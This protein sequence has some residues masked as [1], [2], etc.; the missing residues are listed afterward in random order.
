ME[1]SIEEL[2]DIEVTS[3]SKKKQKLYDA[4]AAIFVITHDDIRRSGVTSIPD[5]L[6][7]APGLEVART[8]SARWAVTSRGFNDRFANKLLVLIDGRSIYT[9]LF[10]GV[11]W[12][13]K[14]LILDDI[15]RI[16]IIRGPGATLWG[17]NAVNGVINII[18]KETDETHGAL[19]IIGGGS[20][21]RGFG[22]VR[23]GGTINDNSSYRIFAK[24]FNRDSFA[25]AD[26]TDAADGWEN[27]T[28]GF[29]VDWNPS[30][31]DS[32]TFSGGVYNGNTGGN[33]G[34][35][36]L[37]PPFKI[38]IDTDLDQTGGHLLG[39][40]THIS[41]NDSETSLQMYY[42]RTDRDS[43]TFGEI[44][45]TFDVDIQR[46][47][48]LL[49]R[50]EIVF[51]GRYRYTVD[52]TDE[53][54]GDAFGTSFDPTGRGDHLFS[55]FVQDEITLIRDRLRLTLGSKFEHNDYTGF[56]YQPNIR[57]AW[58]PSENQTVWASVSRAVR[59]PARIEDDGRINSQALQNPFNPDG[60]PFLGALFGDHDAESEDL[61]AFEL[62]YRIQPT[63]R[64]SI[65][66]AGFF[67]RYDS[68]RTL[69]TG[70]L[71]FEATNP[72][73]AH[74]L[75]PITLN[76]GMDGETYGIEVS[77]DYRP[78]DWFRLTGYYTYLDMQ[79]H[80]DN[81]SNDTMLEAAEGQSP[82]NQFSLRA[83]VDL[84]WDME[85]DAWFRYV[86][87]LPALEIDSYVTLD[88]RVG[89]NPTANLELE[90]VGQNLLDTEHQEFSSIFFDSPSIEIERGIYGSV[91]LK[92]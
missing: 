6:R 88:I 61:L 50:H 87:Q 32:V 2:M 21:E 14:D 34:I 4:A 9:P 19:A 77:A 43:E 60:P 23:Y 38:S 57:S 17:A 56:E 53:R 55:T 30:D 46:R 52:K 42:D 7:L 65:D 75:I 15:E 24:Y 90:I 10:S 62:G 76:N 74:F 71:A 73:P 31:A 45:D 29:R 37:T 54:A 63:N 5:A 69:E 64:L 59:T 66:V 20:D 39:R 91:K 11:Y 72:Q 33:E 82:E 25:T 80:L 35:S 83:I 44:R 86:D 79:L 12:E 49:T 16:E 81:D 27:L 85:F 78:L 70:S 92:F 51:G 84:P 68:L 41:S 18:T 8:D 26:G 47:L 3:V 28:A 48:A 1:L 13:E 36:M 22:G 67:N 40:W 89:W 58:T